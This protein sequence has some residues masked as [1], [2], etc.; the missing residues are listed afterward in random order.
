MR[1]QL[2]MHREIQRTLKGRKM[3]FVVIIFGE[4]STRGNLISQESEVG[5]LQDKL[6]ELVNETDDFG[7][8]FLISC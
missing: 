6:F 7:C 5:S 1:R 3:K 2:D 8:I 4:F